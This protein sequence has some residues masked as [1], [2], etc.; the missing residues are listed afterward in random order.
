MVLS[1][2][3][4]WLL[5]ASLGV[6]VRLRDFDSRA[7]AAGGAPGVTDPKVCPRLLESAGGAAPFAQVAEVAT[8]TRLDEELGALLQN[9]ATLKCPPRRWIAGNLGRAAIELHGDDLFDDL[10]NHQLLRRD[11]PA[12]RADRP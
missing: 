10:G 1:F 5:L 6:L 9:V 3:H 4:Q 7:Q 2:R 11:Q 12:A 8:A